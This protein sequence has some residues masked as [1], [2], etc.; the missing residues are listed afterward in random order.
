L[1]AGATADRNGQVP[2]DPAHSRGQLPDATFPEL[3]GR[4]INDVSDL[5]DTQIQL[6]KQEINEAKGDAIKA[7]TKIAIGA[8]LVLVMGL[9]I[10]IWAW[11]AYIWFFNWLGSFIVIGPV[12]LSFLGW[13]LGAFVPVAFGYW[14]IR[15]WIQ[16]GIREAGEIWPPLERTRATLRE[17]LEWLQSQRTRSLR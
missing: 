15:W 11:T 3:I 6:A 12:T 9:F 5:A 4:I 2:T 7:T 13:I 17:H 16:V 8:G 10:I 14:A 1:E